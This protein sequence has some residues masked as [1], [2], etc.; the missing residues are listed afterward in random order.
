MASLGFKG[1][2][3]GETEWNQWVTAEKKQLELLMNQRG[4][5]WEKKGTHEE[6]LS[7]LEY[8]KEQRSKEVKK[9]EQLSDLLTEKNDRLTQDI[10]VR[11]GQLI[12]LGQEL[13]EVESQVLEKKEQITAVQAE[14]NVYDNKFA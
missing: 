14:V 1:G 12:R 4:I 3:R 5:E 10:H 8:K 2:T 13:Q 11:Q 7:V 6:H 9:L